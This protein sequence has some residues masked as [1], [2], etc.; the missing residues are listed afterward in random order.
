MSKQYLNM[1]ILNLDTVAAVNSQTGEEKEEGTG[2]G[3]QVQYI[4]LFGRCRLCSNKAS[5]FLEEF[6]S[7]LFCNRI[8]ITSW[9][10]RRDSDPHF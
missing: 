8:A 4:L 3:L 10:L 9:Q 2:E 6:M 1:S 7:A 5:P